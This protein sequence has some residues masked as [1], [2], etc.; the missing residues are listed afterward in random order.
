MQ[1]FGEP[2]SQLQIRNPILLPKTKNIFDYS[3]FEF[4]TWDWFIRGVELTSGARHMVNSLL[5]YFGVVFLDLAR[6][7]ET[8]KLSATKTIFL[9]TV[10]SIQ[11]KLK[12]LEYIF[13]V[14]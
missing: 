11:L 3:V 12:L 13:C 4:Q 2:Q 14:V 10:F 6:G 7:N 9:C 1:S 5:E 8:I